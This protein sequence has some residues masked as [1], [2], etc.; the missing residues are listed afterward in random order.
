MK[1]F[2]N[3]KLPYEKR[4][5]T[6]GEKIRRVRKARGLTL[7]QVSE[8]T[9]LSIGYL[10]Q[11]ERNKTSPTI[12]VLKAIGDVLGKSI[13]Y[14]VQ[15]EDVKPR[16]VVRKSD[17]KRLQL[18]GSKLEFEL[19]VPDLNRSLEVLFHRIEVGASSGPKPYSHVGE[20]CGI[21]LKGRIRIW[22]GSESFVLEE[23]D[24][25]AFPSSLPHR[26]E[27]AG[28]CEAE[29]IWIITPPTY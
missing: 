6:L 13:A 22:I 19:L 1:K 21:V 7:A 4:G 8:K 16:F 11:V 10:S 14:F 28:D 9:G 24:S 12:D 23:G 25:V 20:E 18:P 2:T 27:N 3:E 29:T 26:W 5:S 17:R 15:E